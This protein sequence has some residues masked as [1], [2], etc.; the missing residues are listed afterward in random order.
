[1]ISDVQ[2]THFGHDAMDKRSRIGEATNTGAH[3]VNGG[4][5]KSAMNIGM[6]GAVAIVCGLLGGCVETSSGSGLGGVTTKLTGGLIGTP[7]KTRTTPGES[8]SAGAVAL[9]AGWVA[10]DIARQLDD[11]D[12]RAAAEADFVALET[13]AAGVSREW[14]NPASGR[15]GQ[16]TPG[17]AYAVNQ[18]TCR[19]FVDVVTIDGRK[20]TR[21]STACRQPDGSW[22][23]IS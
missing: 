17:P 12:R 21:R 23:P 16:V 22:R 19:D 11:A 14:L 10:A 20:D 4:K 5:R 9:Y 18:Y 8:V 15:R 6:I 7:S 2:A 13:G 3:S 1:M